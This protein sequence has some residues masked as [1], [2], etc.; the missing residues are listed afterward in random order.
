MK[1]SGFKIKHVTMLNQICILFPFLISLFTPF[2]ITIVIFCWFY[3]N[4]SKDH[5][6]FQISIHTG[7]NPGSYINIA[8]FKYISNYF[9]LGIKTV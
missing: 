7:L 6:N 9:L 4:T 2:H 5:D 1:Q 3:H 8:V